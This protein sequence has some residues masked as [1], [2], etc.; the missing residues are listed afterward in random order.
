[1]D[2]IERDLAGRARVLRLNVMGEV[3]GRLAARYDVRGVPTFLV[4]DGGGE[5]VLRQV[6]RPQRQEIMAA[7]EDL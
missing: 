4:L 2:G 5:I 3:G 1:M 6:G 7:I